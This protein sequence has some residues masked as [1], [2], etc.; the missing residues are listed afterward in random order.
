MVGAAHSID[1]YC[2]RTDRDHAKGQHL[3][4]A[5]LL[6]NGCLNPLSNPL[7]NPLSSGPPL[8]A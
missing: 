6:E 1:V 7:L 8:P 5:E 3:G 4:A 2:A